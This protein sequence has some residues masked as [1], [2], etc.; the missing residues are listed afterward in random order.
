MRKVLVT[1]LATLAG[2]AVAGPAGAALFSSK[3]PVIAILAD[4]LFLGEATGDL[5]GSGTILIHSRAAPE[6][7]C[8]GQF[9]SSAEL[10]GAGSMQCSDGASATFR[11]Q[12]LSLVRGH[13]SGSSTRGS[14]SFTYGL[15]ASESAPYLKLPPGKALDASVKEPVLVDL[16]KQ[17][18][19]NPVRTVQLASSAEIAPDVLLGNATLAITTRLREQGTTSPAKIAAMVESLIL[20]LFDFRHMTQLAV[21]RGWPLASPDQQRSLATEFQALLVRTYSSALMNYR[22]QAITYRP[23]RIAPGETEVTVKS[24]VRQSGSEPLAIDYDMQRMAAG[25]KV[26]DVK[27]AGISLVTTYRSTFAQII[28][29]TGVDGLIKSLAGKNRELAG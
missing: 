20:P 5:D 14:L 11:F 29:D 10:G 17:I 24:T 6:L 18:A 21:A 23:L 4:E 2:I 26:Y 1:L 25:W 12:R 22:D 9:T 19:T 15:T 8:R 13:G 16:V 7:T 27:I 28:R 3:G